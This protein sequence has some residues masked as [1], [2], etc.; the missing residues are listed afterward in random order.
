MPEPTET[1]IVKRQRRKRDSQWYRDRGKDVPIRFAPTHCGLH[2]LSENERWLIAQYDL[3][4]IADGGK[5]RITTSTTDWGR[6]AEYGLMIRKAFCPP[7]D[8]E[9]D[10]KM[11][12]MLFYWMKRYSTEQIERLRAWQKAAK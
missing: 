10:A 7:Q 11:L 2:K 6:V 9:L 1:P 3:M 4:P 5:F 8:Q 12:L